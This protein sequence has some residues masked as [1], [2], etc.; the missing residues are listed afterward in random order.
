V[1]G[2]D[3]DIDGDPLTTV[4]VADAEHGDVGLNSNGSFTYTPDA[5]FFGTDTFTYQAHDGTGPGNT[6]TVTITVTAVNDA[7]VAVA[8][9]YSVY[10]DEVLTHAAPGVLGNDTDVD[11]GS[12]TASLVTSTSHGALTFSSS[13]EFTYTPAPN[14]FGPDSFVYR[15]SDGSAQSSPVTVN[16]NV[17]ANPV[18]DGPDA[19]N[20][21]YTTPEDTALTRPAPGVL[22]NDTDVDGDPLTAVNASDPAHGS[23]TLNANGSFTYTPDSN[24]N[25]SDSFTYEARDPSGATGTATVNITVTPVDDPPTAVNDSYTMSEDGPP[26]VVSAP[27]VLANDSDP[28]GQPLTAVGFSSA[29]VGTL[30]NTSSSGS[31]RY[32][33]PANFSGT[34]TFTYRARA[35][36]LDSAPATVTITVTP[37]NDPPAAFNN[38]YSGTEDT[39]LT[40]SAPGVLGNDTDPDGDSLT[41]VNGVAITGGSVS[42]NANGS[43]TFTPTAD[44]SGTA[45]FTY[46]AE[47]PSGATDSASVTINFAAVNDAPTSTTVELICYELECWGDASSWADPDGISQYSWDWDYNGSFGQNTTG[48]T[49]SW[50]NYNDNDPNETIALRVTDALGNQTITTRAVYVSDT[51]DRE[52]GADDVGTDATGRWAE[53]TWSNG[54]F[55]DSTVVI[56]RCSGLAPGC[57]SNSVT[58]TDDGFQRIEWNPATLPTTVTYRLCEP[59]ANPRCSNEVVVVFE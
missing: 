40:I 15:A 1:L 21:T 18:N 41:A 38:A 9:S 2:N 26:L 49:S 42:L 27:G 5:N 14:Y 44:F 37:S 19:V 56:Y 23:V 20:D 6:A 31:F 24:Y 11:S 35:G 52:L 16:I 48:V 59:R 7:P 47:D 57:S 12:L 34:A 43:F 46:Q 8:E 32:T 17:I 13:G 25:G 39:P 45:V 54:D 50:D 58:T 10:E 36:G 29:S 4:L 55:R 28:E 30:S 51:T 22:G 3:T 33:P 53:L